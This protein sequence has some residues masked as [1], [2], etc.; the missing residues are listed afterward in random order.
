MR[1]KIREKEKGKI[2]IKQNREY[3]DR[4]KEKRGSKEGKMY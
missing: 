3:R 1:E 4:Q 2:D